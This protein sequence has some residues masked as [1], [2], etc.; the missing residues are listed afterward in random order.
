MAGVIPG[1]RLCSKIA[2]PAITFTRLLRP[3]NL[4]EIYSLPPDFLESTPLAIFSLLMEEL[5]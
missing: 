2:T 5:S 4:G 1:T 3:S